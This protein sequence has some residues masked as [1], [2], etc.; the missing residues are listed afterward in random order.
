[1]MIIPAIETACVGPWTGSSR[2]PAVDAVASLRS[3]CESINAVHD[4]ADEQMRPTDLQR[5][6][7]L[8][9]GMQPDIGRAYSNYIRSVPLVP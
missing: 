7:R 8:C 9:R 6:S 1:M 4:H 5:M 2:L 3:R